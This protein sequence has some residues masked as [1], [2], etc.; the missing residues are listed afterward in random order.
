MPVDP[1]LPV[2]QAPGS[3]NQGGR[4]GRGDP[5]AEPGPGGPEPRT[6]PDFRRMLT[7][8]FAALLLTVLFAILVV[9][10]TLRWFG[11]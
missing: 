10:I 7:W 9:E 8:V 3:A 5:Q 4:T 1:T 2:T 6:D 11:P